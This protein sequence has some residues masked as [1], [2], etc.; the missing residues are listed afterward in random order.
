MRQAVALAPAPDYLLR[1]GQALEQAGHRDQ[2][3][4]AYRRTLNSNR[5][6]PAGGA[7]LREARERLRVLAQRDDT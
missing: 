2:A 6:D 7:S 3:I 5:L 1:L 4:T